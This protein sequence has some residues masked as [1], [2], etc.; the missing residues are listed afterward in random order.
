MLHPK[1]IDLGPVR[2]RIFSRPPDDSPNFS[3]HPA[4]GPPFLSEPPALRWMTFSTVTRQE[5]Q[6]KHDG[7]GE[8]DEYPQEAGCSHDRAPSTMNLAVEFVSHP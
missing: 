1:G 2:I 8:E 3:R 7:V 5:K 6:S 4:L